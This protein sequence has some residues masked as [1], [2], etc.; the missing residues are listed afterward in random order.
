M[1]SD[2]V[3]KVISAVEVLVYAVPKQM[4]SIKDTDSNHIYCSPYLLDLM[5]ARND[6]VIGTKIWTPLY[7]DDPSF[8]KIIIDEDRAIIETKEPKI[9]LK[10]NKFKMGLTPYF[11]QKSPLINPVNNQV[12]GIIVQGYEVGLTNFKNHFLKAIQ[13][14]PSEFSNMHLTKREKQVIYFFMSHLSSQEIADVLSDIE[15]KSISKSTIDCVFNEQLYPKFNAF[16]RPD[17]YHKLHKA[18]FENKI[19]QEMLQSG[20]FFLPILQVF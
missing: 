6:Q 15:G 2:F 1:L 10:I 12:E 13:S 19:P 5:E 8:E 20:S 14:K 3:K 18:G 9:L 16:S 7:G 11:C 17:L 4:I